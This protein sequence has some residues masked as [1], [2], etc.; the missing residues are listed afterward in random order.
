[1]YSFKAKVSVV[2]LLTIVL[3]FLGTTTSL[4]STVIYPDSG[5]YAS[6]WG[7]GTV[8]ANRYAKYSNLPQDII[9]INYSL[10]SDTIMEMRFSRDTNFR[11]EYTAVSLYS[12]DFDTTYITLPTTGTWY[13]M[14][15]TSNG[16]S[17]N[18][19]F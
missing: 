14:V 13:V 16:Q 12:C 18:F 7:E 17:A 15:C 6:G 9:T 1:M 10:E 8:F 4:A 19:S 11:S 2:T 5:Y 3:L